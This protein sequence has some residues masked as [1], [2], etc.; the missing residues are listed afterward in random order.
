R[1]VFL[2]GEIGKNAPP[3]RHVRNPRPRHLVRPQPVELPSARHHRPTARRH[4]AGDAAQNAGLAGAVSTQQHEHLALLEGEGHIAHREHVAIGDTQPH[5][6]EQAHA[7]PVRLVPRYA[8][9][10][11]G[12]CATSTGAPS[13]IT[14][15]LC[16]TTNRLTIAA[17]TDS[18]CSTTITVMPLARLSARISSISS[19][20]SSCVRPDRLSS[21]IST[22]QCPAIARPISTFLRSAKVIS[23]GS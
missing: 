10:T 20:A 22:R 1:E 8:S 7:N 2:H 15:A 11:A 12:S 18:T 3:F 5:D 9:I 23:D 21:S 4:H 16:S 13:A 17:S 19:S 6:G 14:V